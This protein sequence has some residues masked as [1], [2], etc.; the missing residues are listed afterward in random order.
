MELRSVESVIKS[1]ESDLGIGFLSSYSLNSKLK[2][3][4]IPELYVERRFYLC[5]KK[6]IRPGLSKLADALIAEAKTRFET[7]K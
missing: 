5:H 2:V 7:E 3:I 6:T 4:P 1:I